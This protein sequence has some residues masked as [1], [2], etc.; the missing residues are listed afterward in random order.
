MKSTMIDGVFTFSAAISPTST[1][2]L[3]SAITKSA[4]EAING[5]KF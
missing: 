4:A 1:S 2:S 5:L 3:I